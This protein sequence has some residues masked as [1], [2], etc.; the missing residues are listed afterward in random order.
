MARSCGSPS[1]RHCRGRGTAERAKGSRD[2]SCGGGRQLG[3]GEPADETCQQTGAPRPRWRPASRISATYRCRRPHR[4]RRDTLS[5]AFRVRGRGGF[6]DSSAGVLPCAGPRPWV[7]LYAYTHGHA[8]TTRATSSSVRSS[9]RRS[10]RQPPSQRGP[11]CSVGSNGCSSRRRSGS[12]HV[13]R[14]RLRSA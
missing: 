9:E 1:R 13:V 3:R 10:A 5:S 11:S 8:P 2:R 6:N 14:M 7:A 4:S 12:R